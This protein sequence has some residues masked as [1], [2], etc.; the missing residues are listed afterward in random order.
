MK[1]W[2]EESLEQVN[3]EIIDG[4]R[5]DN[6]P[7]SH[8]FTKEGYCLFL[9][10]S[11]IKNDS[12]NLSDINFIDEKKDSM[13]RKGKLQRND[14][15]I[16]TRGTIGSIAYYHDSIPYDQIRINSGM[17]IIRSQS[18]VDS[19]YL[20]L[21]FRSNYFKEQCFK[22]SSGSAQPQ[23]PIKDLKTIKI[24][25]PPLPT[26]QRIAAILS[27]YDDLI[28]NNRRRITLLEDSARLLYKEWFVKFQFPGHEKVKVK[29]GLPVGWERRKIG[30][31]AETVGGGTP[32]TV[33]PEYWNEGNITWFVPK[34]LTNNGCL[35]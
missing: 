3:L 30:D 8:E 28:E 5:G 20:Y 23:L 13:L 21:A 25:L 15:V 7:K 11:N 26:Q 33:V 31:I 1:K 6:Y 2:K 22:R 29:N 35:P 14:I 12:F 10:T 16:T 9:N 27:S 32:S 17:V 24:P 34:D 19:K 18:N 4:D